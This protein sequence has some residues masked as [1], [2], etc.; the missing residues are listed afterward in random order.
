MCSIRCVKWAPRM[1]PRTRPP[2]LRSMP[3]FYHLSMTA[4]SCACIVYWPRL[5]LPP[6]KDGSIFVNTSIHCQF[7]YQM[8]PSTEMKASIVTYVT[9]ISRITV[10]SK[11]YNSHLF[12]TCIL[13]FSSQIPCLIVYFLLNFI[14]TLFIMIHPST[15]THAQYKV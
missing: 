11:L 1:T 6:D 15:H 7:P 5:S 2:C 13:Y 14:C 12:T 9:H 3:C 10:H 4:L 8:L